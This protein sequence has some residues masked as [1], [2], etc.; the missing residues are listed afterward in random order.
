MLNFD[1]QILLLR[2]PNQLFQV[3]HHGEETGCS[4]GLWKQDREGRTDCTEPGVLLP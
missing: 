4:E 2:I 1:G 3:H